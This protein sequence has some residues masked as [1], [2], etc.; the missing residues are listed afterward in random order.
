MLG[1]KLPAAPQRKCA[2]WERVGGRGVVLLLPVLLWAM[3]TRI[4][5]A[6][7]WIAS[8]WGARW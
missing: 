5:S 3:N 6:Q 8:S 2:P 1:A 4:T 7:E